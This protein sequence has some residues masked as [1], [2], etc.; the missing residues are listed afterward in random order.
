MNFQKQ[1]LVLWN[2]KPYLKYEQKHPI[3]IIQIFFSI[4]FQINFGQKNPFHWDCNISNSIIKSEKYFSNLRFIIYKIYIWSINYYLLTICSR[5]NMNDYSLIFIKRMYWI[6]FIYS[7]LNCFKTIFFF[8][9][10]YIKICF[11]KCFNKL[12]K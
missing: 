12:I 5:C 11:W 10:V 9:I 4:F 2:K 3:Y 8:W 6:S 1:Y 7:L